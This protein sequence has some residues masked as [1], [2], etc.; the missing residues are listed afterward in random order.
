MGFQK[1]TQHTADALKPQ[2]ITLIIDDSG[3]MQGE[4]AKKATASVQDLVISLQVFNKSSSGFRHVVNIAKF[5]DEP[6]PLAVASRPAEVNLN[7]LVFDG[8]SGR[9]DMPRALEWARQAVET[10]LARCRR[11]IPGY[12][13]ANAPNPLCVF[14]SDGENTGGDVSGPALALRS[15]PFAGGTVDVVAC[16]IGLEAKDVPTMQAIASR[17]EFSANIDP[18][19]LDEFIATVGKTAIEDPAT[20]PERIVEKARSKEMRAGQ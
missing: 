17:P 12:K 1:L 10:A 14:L 18:S 4:K 7:S 16:G 20:A 8:S 13:E 11:D 3:S 15:I 5:G 2:V 19:L 9:T 6:I